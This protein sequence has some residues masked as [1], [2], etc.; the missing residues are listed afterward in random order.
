[1]LFCTVADAQYLKGSKV[2]VKV[3]IAFLSATLIFSA[4]G[5]SATEPSEKRVAMKIRATID[6]ADARAMVNSTTI[7][8]SGAITE[9]TIELKDYQLRVVVEDR[10]SLEFSVRLELFGPNGAVVDS[11]TILT[12]DTGAEPFE[13]SNNSDVVTGEIEVTD[14]LV[15]RKE[16]QGAF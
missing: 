13:L 8:K 11:T 9:K 3:V 4:T 12:S 16:E 1:M 6:G 10:R 2:H 5:A 15:G 14:V 7:A